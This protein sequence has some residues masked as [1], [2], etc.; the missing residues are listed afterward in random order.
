M[1]YVLSPIPKD[2]DKNRNIVSKLKDTTRF[3][4]M[5][6]TDMFKTMYV[7]GK[8]SGITKNLL[9]LTGEMIFWCSLPFFRFTNTVFIGTAQCLI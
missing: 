3:S 1:N 4:Q 6:L 2:S 9:A 8:E 5:K 7:N